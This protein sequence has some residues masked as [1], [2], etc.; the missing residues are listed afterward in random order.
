MKYYFWLVSFWDGPDFRLHDEEGEL[1]PASRCDLPSLPAGI[2]LKHV[3]GTRRVE[4]WPDQVDIIKAR[5]VSAKVRAI[6]SENCSSVEFRSVPVRDR[7]GKGFSVDYSLMIPQVIDCIDRKHTVPGEHLGPVLA[8][9]CLPPEGGVYILE[10]DLQEIIVSEN[11]VESIKRQRL[12]TG[13]FRLARQAPP[14]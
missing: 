10:T 14:N 1:A 12:I 7:A 5:F 8:L 13:S 3:S 9:G 11:I 6:L 2:Y 4:K